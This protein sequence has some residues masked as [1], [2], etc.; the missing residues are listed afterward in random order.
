MSATLRLRNPALTKA[1]S[2]RPYGG[3][4]TLI[5]ARLQGNRGQEVL[6]NVPKVSSEDM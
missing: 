5:H 2:K 6:H 3:N 4:T 1:P